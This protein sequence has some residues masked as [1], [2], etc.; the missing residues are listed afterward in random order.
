MK[1]ITVDQAGCIGCGLCVSTCPDV[2]ELGED[3]KSHVKDASKCSECNCQQALDNC[4]SKA[5]SWGE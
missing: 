5:I 2:F 4:P 1:N 3:G